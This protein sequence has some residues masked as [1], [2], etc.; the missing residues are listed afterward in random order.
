MKDESKTIGQ[1]LSGSGL[2]VKQFI[3]Y[4]VGEVAN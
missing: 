3:R 1:L 2:K 4:R